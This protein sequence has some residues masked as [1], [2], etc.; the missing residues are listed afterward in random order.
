MEGKRIVDA[1]LFKYDN[2]WYLFFGEAGLAEAKLNLWISNSINEEFKKHPSNPICISPSSARMAG[3][4]LVTEDGIF[5]FGQNN[6]RAYGASITISEITKISSDTY[7]EKVCGTIKMDN[8]YGPHSIDI[9]KN[10]GLAI[11]D[12]YTDEFSAFAGVRRVKA[13]IAKIAKR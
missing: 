1:T 4:I 12:Y 3:R 7:E 2:V 6:N 13:K 5:R 11:I 10:N 8:C 9:N